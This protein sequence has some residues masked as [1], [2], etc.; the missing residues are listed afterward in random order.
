MT[1]VYKNS[2]FNI[3]T[4]Y[5]DIEFKPLMKKVKYVLDIKLNYKNTGDHVS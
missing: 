3:G 1:I 2:G 5:I 4:I